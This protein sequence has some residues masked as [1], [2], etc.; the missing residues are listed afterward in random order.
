[1]RE[2]MVC[3]DGVAEALYMFNINASHNNLLFPLTSRLLATSPQFGDCSW[4]LSSA[5]RKAAKEVPQF[6]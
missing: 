1:V 4:L 3:G 6:T 2:A 5:K